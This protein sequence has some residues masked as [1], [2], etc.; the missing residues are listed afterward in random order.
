M[1][2]HWNKWFWTISWIQRMIFFSFAC[3]FNKI[4]FFKELLPVAHSANIERKKSNKVIFPNENNIFN[5]LFAT[6]LLHV[7]IQSEAGIL[8]VMHNM[9][10]INKKLSINGNEWRSRKLKTERKIFFVLHT[11]NW[12]NNKKCRAKKCYH[13]DGTYRRMQGQKN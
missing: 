4:F 2:A 8:R 10:T 3:F 7:C 9:K 13:N 5:S 11:Q 6:A 12:S 1:D